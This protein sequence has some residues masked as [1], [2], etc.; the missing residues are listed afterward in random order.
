ML[1]LQLQT[2]LQQAVSLHRAGRFREAIDLYQQILRGKPT[3]EQFLAQVL[4]LLGSAQNS[5]G[6]STEGRA[7]IEKAVKLAPNQAQYR[8][9]LSI[10][11]KREGRMEEAR[12]TLAKAIELDPS[13]PTFRAAMAE[14]HHLEGDFP[15]AMKMIEPVLASAHETPALAIMFGTVAPHVKRQPEA[16]ESL[17]KLLGTPGLA[18]TQRMKALFTL[19]SLHDSLDQFDEA[20]EAY[21]QGNALSPMRYDSQQHHQAIDAV[22]AAWQPDVVARLPRAKQH[23]G[24]LLFIVG[25]P[26]SATTLVEQILSVSPEVFAAGELNDMPRLARAAQGGVVEGYPMITSPE[27]LTQ[28]VVDTAGRGYHETVRRLRPGS[29]L[30]I[31]K[32]PLN[33]INLGLI[34]QALPGARVIHCRRNPIDTCLSCYFQLFD[35]NLT[36]AYSLES[37]AHFHREYERLMAHWCSVLTMPIMHVDYE[38]L[39]NEQER[40]SREIF[41]FAGLPWTGDAL[42]FHKS[43]RTA[44]TSSNAQVRQPLYTR[45]VERWRNYAKFLAP[46]RG[47]E[48]PLRG[49]EE[50][51]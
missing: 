24:R 7:N 44:M 30:F 32:L 43:R 12:R 51:R 36:F 17:R 25:M 3:N 39:I 1:S 16:I 46:L 26:R 45:S 15:Q 49:G 50:R 5:L 4:S 8:H 33:F 19:G 38:V 2:Q 31:D 10:T 29:R 22:L 48:P 6:L 13:R 28:Q 47:G 20:F 21:S 35:G 27:R 23:A 18:T 34:Q 9:D 11:Y 42:R 14:L 40:V 37:I 41:E